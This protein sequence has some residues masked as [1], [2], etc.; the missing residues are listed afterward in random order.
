MISVGCFAMALT[1]T[2][3]LSV[4]SHVDHR[5]CWYTEDNPQ[6]FSGRVLN[7]LATLAN[8]EF[9]VTKDPHFFALRQFDDADVVRTYH[10]WSERT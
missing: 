2:V 4:Q 8:L 6:R 7:I 1:G 5:I 3:V 9:Q 10:S